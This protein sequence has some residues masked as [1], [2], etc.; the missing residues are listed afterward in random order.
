MTVLQSSCP[1][2]VY[3]IYDPARLS[4]FAC[5]VPLLKLGT[6]RPGCVSANAIDLSKGEGE[7]HRCTTTITGQDVAKV[8]AIVT[9]HPTRADHRRQLVGYTQ[10]YYEPREVV[11]ASD[12]GRA[13][14][15]V[16]RWVSYDQARKT[17]FAVQVF[18]VPFHTKERS[19]A[20]TCTVI[21]RKLFVW[22]PVMYTRSGYPRSTRPNHV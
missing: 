17:R 18:D 10:Q 5:D 6:R 8:E 20:E 14:T 11:A 16:S 21:L 1:L 15:P 3:H 4:K 9:Y 19:S 13:Q 12:Q 7:E 22:N 2:R